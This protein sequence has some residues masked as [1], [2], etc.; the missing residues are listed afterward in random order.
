MKR[1]T[2]LLLIIFAVTPIFN[3]QAASFQWIANS[4]SDPAPTPSSYA[5]ISANGFI[6]AGSMWWDLPSPF[7]WTQSEGLYYLPIP[8]PYWNGA[9]NRVSADGSAIVGYLSDQNL[10]WGLYY[11]YAFRWTQN[12][13]ME[14]LYNFSY[15]QCST[16][17]DVSAD[18]SVVIGNIIEVDSYGEHVGYEAFRWTKNDGMLGLG[19]LPGKNASSAA[20][21]SANGSVIIGDSYLFN[22]PGSTEYEAFRW[23][24]TNGMVGLGT[25]LGSN[26][27][28]A[29]GISADG[30]VI[31][32]TSGNQAFHWTKSGGMVGLGML[33]G[34]SDSNASDLSADGSVVVGTS[35]NEAFRWTKSG[36]MDGLGTLPGKSDSAAR[37][38]SI[39]GTIV[40][41][42]SGGEVF[43]W[44][45]TNG[46][47]SLKGILAADGL[48]MSAN[49]LW[50]PTGISDDGSTIIGAGI[51]NNTWY[52]H[53]SPSQAWVARIDIPRAADLDQNNDSDG[54]DLYL[55]NFFYSNNLYPY[56]DIN[57]DGYINSDDVS[58]FAIGFGK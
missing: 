38:V 30:S 44:D 39:D 2:S 24:Q 11:P 3:V 56:A 51:N 47:R 29:G 46:M 54:R 16:A 22:Y 7:R 1:Y 43:V 45:G 58:T 12:D 25:L 41:G 57:H 48:D 15:Y 17:K 50:Y 36:G 37:L 42:E 49:E 6:V 8:D 10:D 32:G 35:G 28:K 53:G 9:A 52:Y 18:G 5:T 31:I 34:K 27:S 26:E 4:G 19:N 23:T 20:G 13:G 55:F 14:L 40:V 33:P 21:L